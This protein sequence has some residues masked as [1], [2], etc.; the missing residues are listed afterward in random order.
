MAAATPLAVTHLSFR[1]EVLYWEYYCQLSLRSVNLHVSSAWA[2]STPAQFQALQETASRLGG[3][4]VYSVL[5]AEALLG[6]GS[7]YRK[8]LEEGQMRINWQGVEFPV[9]TI[10]HP[11]FDGTA[12]PL[13]PYLICRVALGRSTVVREGEALRFPE[14]FSSCLVQ[15]S[16]RPG[17]SPLSFQGASSGEYSQAYRVLSESQVLPAAM[18]EVTFEPQRAPTVPLLCDVCGKKNAVVYC[19]NDNA[20][21]CAGCDA[22]H[23][24]QNE[25]F[26]RHQR[27]P[28]EHAPMQFGSCLHHTSER[29]ESVC[30]DCNRL[31]C[32]HCLVIG[33]HADQE[34]AGHKIM[35]TIEVFQMAMQ[36]TADSDQKVKDRAA[37][38]Q[39]TLYERHSQLKDIHSNFE[40]TQ[41]Q[42]D[43]VLRNVLEQLSRAQKRRV[44]FLQSFQ[45]QVLSRMLWLQW[46]ENFRAHA[47]LALP[48]AE[49]IVCNLRHQQ[50]VTTLLSDS[51]SG[52][53]NFGDMPPWMDEELLIEGE[54]TVWPA[55][56]PPPIPATIPPGAEAGLQR[57]QGM[58]REAAGYEDYSQLGPGGASGFGF[59]MPTN[60]PANMLASPAPEAVQG[61]SMEGTT[62]MEATPRRG[63]GRQAPKAQAKPAAGVGGPTDIVFAN[64][65]ARPAASDAPAVSNAQ[66]ENYI[67]QA[68]Q[69]FDEAQ[70]QA[71]AQQAREQTLPAQQDTVKAKQQNLQLATEI[72]VLFCAEPKSDTVSP[73]KWGGILE[74][75]VFCPGIERNTLAE[76]ALAIAAQFGDSSASLAKRVIEDDVRRAQ[77]PSLLASA[78]GLHAS[79]VQALLRLMGPRAHFLDSELALLVQEI[80]L[81]PGYFEP[82]AVKTQ[83]DRSISGFIDQLG[84]LTR[85]GV[86]RFPAA[87]ISVYHFLYNAAESKFGA[88]AAQNA[89]VTL[90]VSRII[91]PSLLRVAQR[92]RTGA[93]GEVMRGGVSERI[94]QVSR[95]LQRIAHFAHHDEDAGAGGRGPPVDEVTLQHIADLREVV[96]KILAMPTFA[97]LEL[98]VT[99]EQAEEAAH[100]IVQ[101]AR[102]W[103]Y[104]EGS[105]SGGVADQLSKAATPLAL[106]G[107]AENPSL[108]PSTLMLR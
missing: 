106:L 32:P 86:N 62:Y 87:M 27:F 83:M 94:S 39:E 104:G 15:T 79:M 84:Q 46:L 36:G 73:G 20:Q 44:E 41:Q 90:L 5:D 95:M 102:R 92:P 91:T 4:I 43:V 21:F 1:E 60:T 47:Q 23:H 107:D 85:A 63:G 71:A 82:L 6:P 105:G 103:T 97:T 24:S 65:A 42:M 88:L 96:V 33:P 40:E 31:L 34:H 66:F 53:S 58:Q 50:L 2:L 8:V 7:A 17:G 100:H 38:L 28:M 76:R 54:V 22:E 74:L 12:H 25:F 11:T 99:P 52:F 45:R 67:T 68:L 13:R 37:K 26:A 35:S 14:E 81:I 108:D 78:H 19:K 89:V 48:P 9:G 55:S 30:A 72:L 18:V 93:A 80:E 49:F 70:R 69:Y 61:F 29:Y 10:P 59:G 98:S 16:S 56:M 51:D 3:P 64:E 101:M 77:F 57:L 75:L